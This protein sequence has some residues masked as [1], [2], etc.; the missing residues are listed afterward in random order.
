MYKCHN[1]SLLYREPEQETILTKNTIYP[2]EINIQ[3]CPFC[4]KR[5]DNILFGED[6]LPDDELM[7]LLE[8]INYYKFIKFTKGGN[9]EE[10]I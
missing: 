7:E 9:D 6:E 8:G 5:V 1:C 10:N 3:V 2:H 4:G